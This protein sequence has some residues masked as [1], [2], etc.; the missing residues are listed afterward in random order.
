M[1][2]KY[3][4]YIKE[5]RDATDLVDFEKGI[6]AAIHEICPKVKVV[7]Y[8]KYYQLNIKPTPGKAKRIGRNISRLVPELR[9]F[10]R[11]YESK[12]NKHAVS[13]KLFQLKKEEQ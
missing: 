9:K 3:E 1:N 5:Y 11:E 4:L 7:V 13:R 10:V 2:I 12:G 8:P 6:I